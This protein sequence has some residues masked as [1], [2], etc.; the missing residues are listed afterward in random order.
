MKS[1]GALS[2]HVV[3]VIVAVALPGVATAARHY[4]DAG[5]TATTDI[6]GG[7]EA[8]PWQ[9]AQR[10]ASAD[11]PEGCYGHRLS[12]GCENRGCCRHGCGAESQ[13]VNPDVEGSRPNPGSAGINAGTG[14]AAIGADPPAVSC[15][16]GKAFH[17]EAYEFDP[18]QD[19]P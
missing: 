15:R 10:A 17:V 18:E 16:L 5:N 8:P 1:G 7:S 14:I 12:W 9:T 6:D 11:G 2:V 4:V 3:L 19:A 13:F